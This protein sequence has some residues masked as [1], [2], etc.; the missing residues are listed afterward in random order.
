VS[1]RLFDAP[2]KA[3]P[4]TTGRELVPLPT[5]TCPDC[6]AATYLV[7][8][9]QRALFMHGGYGGTTRTVTRWCAVCRWGHVT[10]QTTEN[11]RRI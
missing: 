4:S 6:G 9:D 11:P 10:E 7:T 5:V 8:Q 3:R 2:A 1:A